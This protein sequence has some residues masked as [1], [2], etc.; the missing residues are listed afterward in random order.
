MRDSLNRG[1]VKPLNRDR[2]NR[3]L[4]SPARADRFS[5][6]TIQRFLFAILLLF[7]PTFAAFSQ[8][9][10]SETSIKAVYLF[11]FA[12]FVDWPDTAFASKESPF[13]I[14][15]YGDEPLAANLEE[16]VA[17][18]TVGGRKLVV[19]RCASLE[20]V[21]GCQ[22]LFISRSRS[23]SVERILARVKGKSIL[24]VSDAENFTSHGG[25]IRFVTERNRVHFRINTEEPPKVGLTISSK[26]LR[27]AERVSPDKS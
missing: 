25:M 6:P 18:E 22:I 12:Q 7:A 23:L 27:L 21:I 24:T 14:G 11:H 15:I 13:V 19:R 5:G 10:S 3:D 1:I 17:S 9:T 20:D 4:P 8:T 2:L 16:A 26:L